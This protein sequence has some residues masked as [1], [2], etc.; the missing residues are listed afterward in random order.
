[1]KIN[2]TGQILTITLLLALLTGNAYAGCVGDTTGTD[3]GCG[4]TVTESCTFNEDM[5]CDTGHGLVIGVDNIVIDGNGHTLNGVSPGICDGLGI[6]RSGIYN[7]AHD[8]ITIRNLEITDFCTG[9][10]FRY[11]DEIGDSVERIAIGNCEIH[12]NGASGGDTTTQGIK[13]I[14][15][16]DSV[17]ADSRIHDNAGSGTA[18]T[19]GGNGIFINGI[20]GVGAWNNT[21]TGN[22]IYNN[23]KAGFLTR[24]MCRDT[25]VS[26]N[27][28]YGN[29]QA[30][31]VLRCKKSETHTIEHNDVHENY[32]AG[33]WIG[34]PDNTIRHNTVTGNRNGS[35]YT[36]VVGEYGS[37]IK[38][39]RAEAHNNRIVS[40]TACG[41][42][43]VDIEACVGIGVTGT[44]GSDN[45]C[46]T[47]EGYDDAGTTGCRYACI[48]ADELAR[49]LT[50]QGWVLYGTDQ[51]PWCVR[52]REEFC[53][54]FGNLTHINCMENKSA[55]TDAGIQG[56][57]CWASP[58]GVLHPGYHNLTTLSGMAGD[59][60]RAHPTPTPTTKMS[61]SPTTIGFGS[62]SAL[63]SLLI[64]FLLRRR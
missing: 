60:Q 40:N 34:G 61:T 5:D 33:I 35:L 18:C 43:F 47:T 48:H 3:Y 14:G 63:A 62:A 24:M 64:V 9:I 52:Q 8:N 44:T 21:I 15:V 17:I 59:Y 16:F 53:D 11:D 37:G 4:G 39:C 28:V 30:G 32:G 13:W 25:T 29:G 27:D 46:D 10:Y 6:E 23:A 36:G 22:E 45:T 41:N 42:D 20:S 57:P 1:M 2:F 49:E 58:D 38:V 55:C 19:S 26:H 50:A 56:I 12:H 31:I 51:C 54:A 7:K